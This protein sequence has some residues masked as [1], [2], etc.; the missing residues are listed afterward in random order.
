MP[1]DGPAESSLT[2]V[3]RFHD[4]VLFKYVSDEKPHPAIQKLIWTSILLSRMR[5]PCIGEDLETQYP[6][7][8]GRMSQ[9]RQTLSRIPQ[10]S[11]PA[12]L[13]LKGPN[14]IS[15]CLSH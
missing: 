15:L 11:L 2:A 6:M 12:F 14:F 10:T 5:F 9:N 8:G 13:V 4:T 1:C 3:V 7:G